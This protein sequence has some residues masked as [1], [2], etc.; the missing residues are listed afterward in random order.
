MTTSTAP[1]I[2]SLLSPFTVGDMTLRNRFA[3]APMSRRKTPGGIPTTESADYYSARA[4]G[5]TGLIITEGTFIDDPAAG[6]SDLIPTL[7]GEEVA[8]GWSNVV[9]RVHD[10]G[11]SILV[12]LWHGGVLR[13][14]DQVPHPGV[15]ARSPSGLD[16]D[17]RPFGEELSTAQ[18]DAIVASYARA[19]EN[20]ERMGFDGVE[21]H[22]AHGYLLDQFVWERTNRRTDRYG[23]A[24]GHGTTLPVEVVRAVRGAVRPGFVVGY[25]FSQW[26]VDRY[27]CRI[28]ESPTELEAILAP[29]ADAGV[30]LLH[31][32][33]RRHWQPEFPEHGGRGLAGWARKITGKPV[34]TVGSVGIDTPFGAEAPAGAS[35]E[36]RLRTLARQFDD[37][38]FDLVAL[39]RALLGDPAWVNKTAGTDPAPITPYQKPV[40]APRPAERLY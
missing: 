32:S 39:G 33:G 24:R 40:V 16:L 20:A 22:G 36:D 6:F 19:A 7:E 31:A 17:G 8:A 13:G 15:P 10:A 38:E 9:D 14:N 37:G 28:A 27:S 26:K 21:I 3:M 11:S 30:D 4:A 25:R 18:I 12:Q 34:I 35:P 23:L 5:G 29:I 2:D 1:L